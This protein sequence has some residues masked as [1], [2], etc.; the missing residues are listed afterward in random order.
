[1]GLAVEA[2]M[3]RPWTPEDINTLQ[4]LL[5]EGLDE[6]DIALRLDRSVSAVKAKAG[7]LRQAR[8]LREE[9]ER[10][11]AEDEIKQAQGATLVYRLMEPLTED[12]AFALG[13]CL[14]EAEARADQLGVGEAF[15]SAAAKIERAVGTR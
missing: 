8:L 1:M 2:R 6:V 3:K 10:T 4:A 12:E 15:R 14:P 11:H 5:G 13:L 7:N 9:A